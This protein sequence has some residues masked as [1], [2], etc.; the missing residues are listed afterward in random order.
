MAGRAVLRTPAGGGGRMTNSILGE[1]REGKVRPIPGN[2]PHDRPVSRGMIRSLGS[3]CDDPFGA[4]RF[5]QLQ[6]LPGPSVGVFQAWRNL[7]GPMGSQNKNQNKDKN[8]TL[9]REHTA[10]RWSA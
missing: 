1:W 9:A 6:K 2:T 7:S 5:P 3:I 10:S 8:Q 4:T